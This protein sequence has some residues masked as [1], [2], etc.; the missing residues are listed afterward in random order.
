MKGDAIPDQ[1]HIARYC[2]PKHIDDGKIQPT[3]FMLKQTEESLSVNWLEFLNPKNRQ[4]EIAE[5]RNIYSLKLTV[6]SR[7]KIAVLNV[8]EVREKVLTESPDRRNLRVLHDPEADDLSHSGIY[9]L[10]PD[11]ELIA[12]LM[13]QTVREDYPVRN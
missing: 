13:L 8:G 5:L 2:S 9:G 7:A 3:A 12:E 11:A 1:N 4:T 10:R 6:R